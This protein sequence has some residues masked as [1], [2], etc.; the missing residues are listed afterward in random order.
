MLSAASV[1]KPLLD[2]VLNCSKSS[3]YC[4]AAQPTYSVRRVE[5]ESVPP[6]PQ[7]LF[8]VY[9]APN[10][11]HPCELLLMPGF[12]ITMQSFLY[13]AQLLSI[14]FVAADLTAL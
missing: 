4:S 12:F 11:S 10:S 8:C 2:V 6:L 14:C 3:G 1:R 5:S 13:L 9:S 7:F